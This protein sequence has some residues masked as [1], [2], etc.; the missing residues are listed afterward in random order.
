MKA[1]HG[2]DV[3]A[4]ATRRLIINSNSF[5]CHVFK[6]FIICFVVFD[7]SENFLVH[8]KNQLQNGHL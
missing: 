1:P 4:E 6:I 8:N 5:L 2:I 7:S 3:N